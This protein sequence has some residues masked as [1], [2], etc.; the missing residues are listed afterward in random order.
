QVALLISTGPTR[1]RELLSATPLYI[2]SK[3]SSILA[4]KFEPVANEINRAIRE[5]SRERHIDGIRKLEEIVNKYPNPAYDVQFLLFIG[6]YYKYLGEYE[7]AIATF[8]RVVN[9]YPNSSLAS[10]AQCAIGIIYEEKLKDLERAKTAYQKVL[11][12]YPQ[13]PEVE[14]ASAGLSRI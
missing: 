13:S 10:I 1:T 14:E 6:A 11:S 5:R 2:S 7:M 12:N 3:R 9:D 4:E 8:E